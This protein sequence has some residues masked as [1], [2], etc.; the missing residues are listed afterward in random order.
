SD[1]GQEIAAKNFYRPRKEAIAQKHSKQFPKLK[2]VTIDEQF[3]GWAKAQKTH[4]SD[5]G[6]FDQIQRAASRQ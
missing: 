2:L 5:G 6:T 1:E 3:A 4:F